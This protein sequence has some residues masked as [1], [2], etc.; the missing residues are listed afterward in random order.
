ML[1]NGSMTRLPT[2]FLSLLLA[3][4]PALH[5]AI[6]TPLIPQLSPRASVSQ[7][8]G[9]TLVSIEYHRP[10]V[11]GRKIWGGLVPFGQIWRTGANEAT[12]IRFSDTVKVEG[13]PIP[14]GTYS[15][16]TIPG[17]DKWTFIL[18]KR[19]KQFGAFEYNPKEDV[20]RVDVKPRTVPFTECL[21]FEIY[22]ASR[23]S[24]Y[25]DLYWEKLRV[26]LYVEVDVDAMVMAR[27]KR[28]MTKA[29]PSDWKIYADGAEYLLDIEKD[30]AQALTWADKSI[31]IAEN[32]VNLFV[33]ARVQK[34]LGQHQQAQQTLERALGIARAR[35]AGP[36][37]LSP[38]QL[39][40]DQWKQPATG[41]GTN[42]SR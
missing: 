19:W 23:G 2:L 8:I 24:A 13:N 3:M 35:K 41:N 27:L 6:E 34:S 32:P 36:V 42:G 1:E 40:L 29:S 15:L 4:S 30:L 22:P 5:S 31:K 10:Q 33:K 9:T 16:F 25:V 18:N 14:A 37:V 39:L 28:A 12:T 20:L 7:T 21:S 11:K 17:P 38:M 26:S